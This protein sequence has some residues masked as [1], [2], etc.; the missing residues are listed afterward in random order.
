MAGDRCTSKVLWRLFFETV[1]KSNYIE[2]KVTH[3]KLEDFES[4]IL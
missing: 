4:S 3:E 2:L 1:Q